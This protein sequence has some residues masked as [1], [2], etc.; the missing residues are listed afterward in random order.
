MKWKVGIDNAWEFQ[1]YEPYKEDL[2]CTY[3]YS[4][5]I[6]IIFFFFWSKWENRLV[7]YLTHKDTVRR[8]LRK[9]IDVDKW[10]LTHQKERKLFYPPSL[11]IQLILNWMKLQKIT[12][13][14]PCLP[15]ALPRE[16]LHILPYSTHHLL[17]DCP[18]LPNQLKY[19]QS[20][21]YTSIYHNI[22]CLALKLSRLFEKIL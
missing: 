8:W 7:L 16:L 15:P 11:P 5:Y 21:T 1:H 18:F 10:N 12:F 3:C 13:I 14:L 22:S 17:Q 6:F 19:Q 4:V 2:K 9:S 20:S